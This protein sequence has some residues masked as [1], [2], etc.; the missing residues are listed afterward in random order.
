MVT[1]NKAMLFSVRKS[2]WWKQ[3]NNILVYFHIYLLV[4]TKMGLPVPNQFSNKTSSS[5][6]LKLSF[7]SHTSSYSYCRTNLC[8]KISWNRMSLVRW[9][10]WVARSRS[11]SHSRCC[12]SCFRCFRFVSSYTNNNNNNNNHIRVSQMRSSSR[13]N[14]KS[15]EI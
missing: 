11:R 3:Y 1:R 14:K 13:V 10:I 7:P 12:R 2:V 5:H 6:F 4:G 15:L 8:K 9:P